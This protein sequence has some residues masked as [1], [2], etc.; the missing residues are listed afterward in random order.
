MSNRFVEMKRIQPRER[1]VLDDPKRAVLIGR[2][3][4]P[5]DERSNWTKLYVVRTSPF[6]WSLGIDY[7]LGV[8]PGIY[9]ALGAMTFGW[10][11]RKARQRLQAEVPDTRS[12]RKR[13]EI[14]EE[15]A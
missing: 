4:Y 1:R 15:Y 13:V 9:W 7:G 12:S 11:V 5:T 10:A 14:M 3:G 8:T 6:W 2:Y